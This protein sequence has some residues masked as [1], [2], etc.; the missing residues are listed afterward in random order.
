MPLE[1]Q[2]SYAAAFAPAPLD[3]ACEVPSVVTGPNGKAAAK[4]SMSTA[5][6]SRLA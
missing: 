5:T 6:M 1:Q 3:P 4:P 2:T